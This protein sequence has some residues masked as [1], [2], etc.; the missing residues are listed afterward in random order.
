M[1]VNNIAKKNYIKNELKK[2]Y[3]KTKNKSN[4][5]FKWFQSTRANAKIK[6]TFV[7]ITKF[8]IYIKISTI[9]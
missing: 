9:I 7:A 2:L 8:D 4:F 5:W 6:S 3:R 1:M